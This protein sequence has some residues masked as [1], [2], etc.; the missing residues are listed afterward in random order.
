MIVDTVSRAAGLLAPYLAEGEGV[1][2]LHLGCDRRLI[3]ATVGEASGEDGLELP[4][5]DIIG[6]ALR[7]G[8]AALIVAHAKSGGD[9]EPS[10]DELQASRRLAQAAAAAGVPLLDHLV[11]AGDDCR[12]LGE[13]GLL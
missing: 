11:F 4:V 13:L 2:V 9:A 8:A 10:E 7:L 5:R 12:S 1:A 3:A 6:V